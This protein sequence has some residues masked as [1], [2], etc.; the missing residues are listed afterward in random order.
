LTAEKRSDRVEQIELREFTDAP[1]KRPARQTR[2]PRGSVLLGKE[3]DHAFFSEP[4]PLSHLVLAKM[5]ADSTRLRE[6]GFETVTGTIVWNRLKPHV[7]HEPSDDAL[8][9]IWGNGIRPFRFTGLG[10][11]SGQGSHMALVPKT[12]GIVSRGEA[13]LVKRMTAKEEPRRLVACR[14][15]Q[16]LARSERGY[17]AENHVNMIRPK[18]GGAKV[19][20]DAVLG[21]LN[22][23]LFDF[24][25]RALN[26]N[27]QVSATELELLPVSERP[28]LGEIAEEARRLTASGGTDQEAQVRLDKLVYRLY[29]LDDEEVAEV[30]GEL[31]DELFAVG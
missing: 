3:F 5:L 1:D 6:L 10:N 29:G 12:A 9:L 18:L 19:D 30:T 21:L 7:R 8:P 20:L 26:G 17:F 13:L 4:N 28:E 16:E 25:F 24:V 14:L 11:R 27:T 2:I 22:S 31:A 23:R 15:P